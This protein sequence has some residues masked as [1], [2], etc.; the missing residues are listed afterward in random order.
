MIYTTGVDMIILFTSLIDRPS[1]FTNVAVDDPEVVQRMREFHTSLV[2][3]QNSLCNVCLECFPSIKT[4]DSG[5]CNRCQ[6]DKEVPVLYSGA[7]NMDPGPVPPELSVSIYF[8]HIV[9]LK[10]SL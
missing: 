4:N 8:I 10:I 9:M 7:N 6:A 2:T 3:L 5:V 1:Q